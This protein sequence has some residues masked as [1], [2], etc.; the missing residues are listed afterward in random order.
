M[1]RHGG[2]LTQ[3]TRKVVHLAQCRGQTPWLVGHEGIHGGVHHG[4]DA[5]HQRRLVR[6]SV[7]LLRLPAQLASVLDLGALL[8]RAP[9]LGGC[10]RCRSRRRGAGAIA[11]RDR[12]RARRDWRAKLQ[13]S[14]RARKR[15]LGF[16][17]VSY[18]LGLLG[19][20]FDGHRLVVALA[21]FAPLAQS[22]LGSNDLVQFHIP[23]NAMLFHEVS[24][25]ETFLVATSFFL[26]QGAFLEDL[27][28]ILVGSIGSV[29]VETVRV[30][31][32][33]RR[34]RGRGRVEGGHRSH[35]APWQGPAECTERRGDASLGNGNLNL[36]RQ[37]Q[38]WRVAMI[39][40]AATPDI[41]MPLRMRAVVPN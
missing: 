32:G 18:V 14:R 6:T 38:R 39:A 1:T 26:F 3:Q 15:S 27:G 22:H 7:I 24:R 11:R 2:I 30:A 25:R 28:G 12:G 41:V 23:R 34:A 36:G 16:L 17:E 40:S 37:D 33:S 19:G 29:G 21:T 35:S 10:R 5:P 8:P 4:A 31:N 9:I 20:P 13:A